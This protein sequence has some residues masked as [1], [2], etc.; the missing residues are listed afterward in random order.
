MMIGAR[1]THR[2][3]W[4]WYL[5]VAVV[6]L[7]LFE[8]VP[9]VWAGAPTDQLRTSVD[10]VIRV[11]DDPS[12]KPASR[13]QERRTAI[14]KVA[15]NIFDFPETAKRALGPHWRSL[16]EKDQ[17]EFVGLFADLLERA[18]LSKIETYS[19]EKIAYTGDT[20]DGDF[21]TVKTR[22]TTKKGTDVPIDYRMLRQGDRWLVYDV[23]VEGVSL[24]NNYRTQFNKIIQTASYQELVT[25]MKNSDMQTPGVSDDGR[26]KAKPRS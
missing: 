9:P 2:G 5:G 16:S 6:G 13:A 24:I 7:W 23:S 3:D 10:E 11:L 19:G 22:F 17:Q 25:R 21:A 1:R 15:D 18:Y 26:A 4:T 8:F 14:R 20:I 12:L